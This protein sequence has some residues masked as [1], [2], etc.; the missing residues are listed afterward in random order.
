MPRHQDLKP[1]HRSSEA[2]YE[3]ANFTVKTSTKLPALMASGSR[4]IVIATQN[5]SLPTRLYL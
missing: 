4:M 5:P 1:D 3:P 2:E